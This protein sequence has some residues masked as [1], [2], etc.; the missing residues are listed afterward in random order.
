M[1]NPTFDIGNHRYE[2]VQQDLNWADAAARAQ[3]EGGHLAALGSEEEACWCF[4][5]SPP[6]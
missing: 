2:L 6:C 3:A 5:P 1:S 4:R